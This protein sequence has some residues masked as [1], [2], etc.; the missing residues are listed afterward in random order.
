M[1]L[2]EKNNV[3]LVIIPPNCTD[4]LQPL[5]LSMNKAAKEHMRNK[6][7]DWYADKVMQQIDKNEEFEP[8]DLH[9]SRIK[10]LGAQ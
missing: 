5:D 10:P 4:R 2:L 7:Q 8:I 6:F 9:L 1:D 3:S